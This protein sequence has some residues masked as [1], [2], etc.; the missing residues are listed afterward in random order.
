MLTIYFVSS[1][2]ILSYI[3]FAEFKVGC[4]RLGF[5]FDTAQE[6]Q[7]AFLLVDKSGDGRVNEEDFVEWWMTEGPN[8]RLREQLH[9]TFKLDQDKLLHARGVAF[10]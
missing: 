8:D 2:P 3:D 1:V 9:S 7:A 4:S 10:G 6:A 5:P